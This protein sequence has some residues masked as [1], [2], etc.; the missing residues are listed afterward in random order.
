MGTTAGEKVK[1]I[2]DSSA[3][4]KL[5]PTIC[6][7]EVYAKVLKVEGTKRAELQ[8]AFIRLR[9]ALIGLTE[10][11]AIESGKIDVEMKKKVVG[12][13]LTDSI[14][15]GTARLTDAKVVTGD[16]YLQNIPK[17]IFIE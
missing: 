12:W 10:E 8:R 2:I 5:T 6:L 11:I 7:A 13:G 4:E 14:V 1:N 15:L 17:A 16:E 9:S 3:E